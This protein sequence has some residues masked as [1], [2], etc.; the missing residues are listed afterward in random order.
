MCSLAGAVFVAGIILVSPDSVRADDKPPAAGCSCPDAMSP[1]GRRQKSSAPK[2]AEARPQLGLGAEI[3]AFE[4]IHLALSEVGDGST[5][6]WHGRDGTISGS[7]RPMASFKD[8]S[9][10]ICRH[11]VLSL[12]AGAHTRNTEG[13]ACRLPDRSWQ[14]EG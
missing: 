5:Y 8:G 11:I 4:A 13:I 6:V 12:S 2:L 7:V 14:L 10:R 9:G 1:E 3:A